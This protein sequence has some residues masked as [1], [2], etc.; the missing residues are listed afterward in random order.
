[1]A[2]NA[3]SWFLNPS[4]VFACVVIVAIV[5]CAIAAPLLAP[6]GP[7]IQL[8]QGLTTG[9]MPLPPSWTHWFGTD[10]LGRSVLSRILYGA[11]ATL[12]V[13]VV[14]NV[15]AVIIGTAVGVLAGMFDGWR[16]GILMR[17][18][19]MMLAYPPLLIA[20]AIAAIVGP[21][22]WIATLVIA[23]SNWTWIA[24]VVYTKTLSLRERNFILASEMLGGSKTWVTLKHM[25]GHV[26]PIM[27]IWGTLG[28][29][30]TVQL[31][32]ALSFLGVGVQPPTASWGNII[33]QNESYFTVAPWL[34]FIPGAFVLLL[35]LAFNIAGEHLQ[36]W[37]EVSEERV[38][39]SADD[40]G[41]AYAPSGDATGQ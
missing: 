38:D 26:A 28:V 1:M 16:R 30:I 7:N 32:A 25:I 3:R 41:A 34:V 15:A 9:G 12:I 27:V 10:V 20:I 2:S 22:M 24:R 31:S 8:S 23:L 35:S 13:G 21:S 17:F 6:V 29:A 14:S 33:Y 5:V 37:F 36:E 11:R 40:E 39:A 19:D 4:F 18:V